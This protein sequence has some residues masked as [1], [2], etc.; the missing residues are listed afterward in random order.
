MTTTRRTFV[1]TTAALGAFALTAKSYGQVVGANERMNVGVIGLNG[2]GQDHFNGLNPYVTALCDCDQQVL[3]KRAAEF[4][5]KYDKEVVQFIDYRE[6]IASSDID[7]VSIATPNHTHSIIGIEA[8]KAGKDV[9]VE[10]PVSHNVW[11]GRQLANAAKKYERIIQCGTQSRSS[12]SLKRAVKFVRDGNLGKIQFAMGT[13]YK[14]RKSIGKLDQ[15]LNIPDHINYDLWCGPAEKR[16]L[17]RPR[18]HYD[19]HWDFNTGNGDMGNQGI[20]QM[21]IARWFLGESTISPKVISIG[22]RVGYQD[23]ADTPNSQTVFHAYENA[24]LIFETRGLPKSKQYQDNRWGSSM[25][26][27]RGSRIG[28]IVQ[29][30]G[31]HVVIPNYTSATAFDADGKEIRKWASGG[32]HY[33]NFAEAVKERDPGKLNAQIAE[34]HISSALCHTGGVSHQVGTKCTLDDIKQAIDGDELFVESFN[35]LVEHLQA[36]EVNLDGESL[37]L[38]K[39]LE[40][41]VQSETVT[42]DEAAN[43]LMSREYRSEFDV[44]GVEA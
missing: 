8:A 44:E 9:Y 25:D 20:H 16:D 34:G 3:E 38:G 26:N 5:K 10:K 35:R 15:A 32:N 7:A 40:F 37:T 21:D 23:A 43:K 31:G 6:L 18:L 17:Y 4:K 11:E 33:E 22:D 39:I 27:Y 12:P 41:D 42:N 2:R 29:C 28:V 13:C 14:P 1:K 19:W 24:P 30:E 36:N